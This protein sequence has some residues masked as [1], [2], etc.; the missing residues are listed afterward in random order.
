MYLISTKTGEKIEAVIEP[1][2]PADYVL[3][4]KGK[5][6]ADFNWDKERENEVFKL[7][8]KGSEDILGL[9]SLI[10]FRK[11]LWLKINLLQTSAENVG[12]K[13]A[14]RRIAGCLIAYACKQAFIRG[15]DGTVALESKTDLVRHYVHT[16][17]MV[18][19]GKHLYTTFVNSENLIQEYLG[20]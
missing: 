3:I 18:V 13:K 11:E 17:G 9:M 20:S 4:R 2:I 8:L 14:F 19:G 6:F 16:Y 1:V 7:R 10:D 15:Y 12:G 5:Q